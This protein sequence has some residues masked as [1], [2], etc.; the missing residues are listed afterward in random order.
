MFTIY[1]SRGHFNHCSPLDTL[2]LPY[3]PAGVTSSTVPLYT[4]YHIHQ[5]GSLQ[6]LCPFT[7]FNIYTSRGHFNHCA[8]L[9]CLPYTPAGVTST[10]VPLYTVY[11]I[12]QQGSLQPL[13][14][15]TLITIYT[16]RG[17]FNH[18]ARV[19]L[20]IHCVY[21]IHQQGSLQPLC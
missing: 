10:T 18:C 2:C 7:L 16:S 21:H 6:P 5:Q 1:T 15:F 14:P 4:D 9:H 13:C 11:H 12:H 20:Q 8:P 19:S 3:T 17:H